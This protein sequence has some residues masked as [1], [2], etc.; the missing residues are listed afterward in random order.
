MLPF[1]PKAAR[2]SVIVGAFDRLPAREETPTKMNEA[3]TPIIAAQVACQ[4]EIPKPKKK[5]PYERARSETL[6]A[7]HGQKRDRGLPER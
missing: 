7:A 5:D 1:T 4:N 6:P 2:E 3:I